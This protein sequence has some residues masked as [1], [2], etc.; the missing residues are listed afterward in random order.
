MCGIHGVIHFN[1]AKPTQLKRE[2]GTMLNRTKHRGPNQ[3]DVI[4]FGNQ[5]ALGMNRL[6]IVAPDEHSTIQTSASGNYAVF[7]GEIVNHDQLRRGLKNPPHQHSDSSIILPLL[8]E[9]GQGYIRELAGMFA[10]GVYNLSEERVQLW[11]DPLG[12]KP[13]Y[14]NHSK[15]G[16]IFSSEIKAIAA[17]MPH[18]P[19][20]D[21]AALDHGLRYRFHPGRSSIFPEIQRVLPGETVIFDRDKMSREQ[22]WT[23]KP[24]KTSL[25][26]GIGIEQFREL[27]VQIIKEHTQADVPGGFFVSGGLDSSLVTAIALQESDSSPYKQPIS[28]RFLP[29]SVVDEGYGK[30]LEKFL[31]KPFEWVDVTDATAR[32][33]LMDMIPF[34]DEPLENPIHIG[35]YLMAKRAHELGLKSVLTGDGSDEFFLGYQ[36]H[37]PWFNG[38]KDPGTAYKKWLWT[39]SPEEANELYTP[40]A[41]NLVKP[42][43]DAEGHPIEPFLNV[44][45]ALRFERLDRLSEYHNMRLDRMTMAHGIEARVPL[46]D[47]RI[48]EF[49]LKIPLPTLFG[50]SGKAWLQEVAKPWVP[51]VIINRKKIHFPSLPDQWLSGEGADWAAEILLDQGART[52][53]WIKPDVLEKY[54]NEHKDNIRSHGRLLWA[55]TVLELWLKNQTSWRNP[56]RS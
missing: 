55:L 28:L 15:D 23:L 3:S 49:A 7:N 33:A 41:A 43:I 19:E 9:H 27:L 44:E 25:E 34:M 47:H 32:Q 24:N 5:V 51:P 14:Y 21:F 50:N 40:D 17:V 53:K 8:E 30:L 12:V 11:R 4:I 48:V 29:N 56:K 35:T 6:S 16:V 54:I 39:M 46:Q 18:E 20:I 38:T 2:I 37:E 26:S 10:I 45:Q 52:R 1:G 36:R 13:L 42:M 31:G 22:Y